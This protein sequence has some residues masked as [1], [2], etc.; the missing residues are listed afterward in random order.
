MMTCAL[1]ISIS[2][3][4]SCALLALESTNTV[5]IFV[6][7]RKRSLSR[8]VVLNIFLTFFGNISVTM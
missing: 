4:Y 2:V 8:V 6:S 1:S 3:Y 7:R 5:L